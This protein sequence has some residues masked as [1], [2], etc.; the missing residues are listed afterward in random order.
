MA[1]DSTYDA[2]DQE[3]A[4]GVLTLLNLKLDLDDWLL[5]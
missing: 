3:G 5:Y 1:F 4:K 2:G